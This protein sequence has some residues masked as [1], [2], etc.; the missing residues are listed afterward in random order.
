MKQKKISGTI[1]RDFSLL[2]FLMA[3]FMSAASV[4]LAPAG[5]QMTYQVLIG[6]QFASAAIGFY[7]YVMLAMSIAGIEVGIF[8]AIRI[9]AAYGGGDALAPMDYIWLVLP[10]A[11]ALGVLGYQLSTRSVESENQSL[12]RQVEEFVLIDPVT[13][14]YNLRMLYRE[15]PSMVSHCQRYDMPLSLLIIHIRY[16][17]ELRALLSESQYKALCIRL[18]EHIA[19]CSAQDDRLFSI[20]EGAFAILATADEQGMEDRQRQI[21]EAVSREG[22]FDGIVDASILVSLRIGGKVYDAGTHMTPM[23]FKLDAE[24]ELVYDV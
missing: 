12:R 16:E 14:Q 2:V 7:G 5:R 9:F 1:M 3:T 20:A 8:A 4:Q 15:I 23:Q 24:G 11:S 19:A 17:N 21:N 13:G 18:A 6:I 10:I 22:A